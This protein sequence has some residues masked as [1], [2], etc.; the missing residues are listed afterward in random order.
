MSPTATLAV[1]KAFIN[2]VPDVTI[3]GF[4]LAL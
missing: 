4:M 3:D 2:D 1:I